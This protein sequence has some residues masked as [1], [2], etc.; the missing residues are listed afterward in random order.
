M[1]YVEFQEQGY[2]LGSGIVESR[3]KQFKP[4]ITGPVM[5]WS[6]AGAECMLAIRPAVMQGDFDA[7][8][9]LAAWS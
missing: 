1:Q 9:L 2:S 3:V 5:R 6:R 7:L 8:W 4:R